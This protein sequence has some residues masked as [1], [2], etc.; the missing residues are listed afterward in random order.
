MMN[1]DA[2]LTNLLLASTIAL[3]SAAT[4]AIL[5]FQRLLRQWECQLE[6]APPMPVQAAAGTAGEPLVERIDALQ[7]IAEQLARKEEMLQQKGRNDVPLEHAV[8]MAK[9]G[10]GV[11]ELTRSCGLK[12]GEAELLM[13]LHANRDPVTGARPH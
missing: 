8:R 10:A 13:K 7:K 1:I 5:R 6:A 2:N 11:E 4:V 3:L 12:K 9:C